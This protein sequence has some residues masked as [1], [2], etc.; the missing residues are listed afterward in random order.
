MLR[1]LHQA[2]SLWSAEKLCGWA[3]GVQRHFFFFFKKKICVK[4]RE[5][6]PVTQQSTNHSQS[7]LLLL[8]PSMWPTAFQL[9]KKRFNLNHTVLQAATF[10]NSTF[11]SNLCTSELTNS[12]SNGTQTSYNE[13]VAAK[14]PFPA[15]WRT[16]TPRLGLLLHLQSHWIQRPDAIF[17]KSQLS[18][19]LLTQWG[20]HFQGSGGIPSL[21]QS[22][23][24]LTALQEHSS[25]AICFHDSTQKY[26][27][28]SSIPL[29]QVTPVTLSH[30]PLS[31]SSSSP[32]WH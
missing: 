7:S 16:L 20:K 21:V 11:L 8:S 6:G 10:P 30:P 29:F 32:Q 23:N 24:A 15:G 12:A 13:G 22:H 9:S 4:T 5:S 1:L 26:T 19:G 17:V 2:S 3:E 27:V 14:Q 31:S 28:W 18:G 25:A